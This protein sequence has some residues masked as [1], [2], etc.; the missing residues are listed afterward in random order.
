MAS[1]FANFVA[2][3]QDIGQSENLH[4]DVISLLTQ[5]QRSVQ[6]ELPLQRDDGSLTVFH[7]YR[8]QH[9]NARGPYKGGVRFHPQ[10][11]EEEIKALAA[12]M[13]LK[14]ALV[15]IPFGGAKGGITVDPHTLNDH[16]LQRLSRLFVERLLPIIGPR[17]DIPAPD[18]NTN[19]QIMAWFMDEYGRL[20]GE[21]EETL[22]TFTGKPISLGGS[23]G[24]EAATGVGGLVVLEEY[25]HSKNL[26]T[27]NLT[28]AVQGF[29]NVGSHFARA[30]DQAGYK[31]VALSD[32]QGG[33]YHPSGLNVAS[34]YQAQQQGGSLAKN[35]C[36][37]KLSV[38]AS[39]QASGGCQPITNQQLLELPVDVLVPAA[40]ENQIHNDNAARLKTKLI[41]ELA[42][43]PTT[44]EADLLLAK[45]HIDIIP[46]ILANA[47]G[48]TV[49]YYEWT[50]NL[51]N[52]YWTEAEV[53]RKLT[54][55]MRLAAQAVFRLSQDTK[56]NLRQAAYR[57]ALE[58]LQEAILLR[59]WVRP[60]PHD[61]AGHVNHRAD[62]R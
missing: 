33:V 9:N 29:G 62:T 56:L 53:N 36:Y 3:I 54:H 31:V 39:G 2:T 18:V 13:T 38:Q 35:V 28:I 1:A 21:G 12:W 17:T 14:T 27:K 40:I 45:K 8:V 46:D 22:A 7:G 32:A 23:H 20:K 51:Q 59:G 4:P 6:I 57:L 60:R 43:G 19:A 58:R 44:P 37:P 16:E 24:R 52:L 25:L 55:K 15:G 26:E 30:A 49:S 47:G 50:Q 61:P 42:N 34:M 10:V 48:V 11:D 5:P 41:L